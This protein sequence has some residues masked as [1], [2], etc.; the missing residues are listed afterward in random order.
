[1]ALRL[2]DGGDGD[3]EA[4]AIMRLQRSVLSQLGLQPPADCVSEPLDNLALKTILKWQRVP[5]LIV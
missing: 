4:G 2:E 1:M 5:K 3:V